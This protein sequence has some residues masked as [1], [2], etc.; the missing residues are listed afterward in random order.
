MASG[1]PRQ[2]HGNP[3]EQTAGQ[4]VPYRGD[5]TPMELHGTMGGVTDLQHGERDNCP[6]PLWLRHVETVAVEAAWRTTLQAVAERS[7]S[8]GEQQNAALRGMGE[9]LGQQVEAAANQAAAQQLQQAHELQAL[10][11][12][13]GGRMEEQEG[14]NSALGVELQNVREQAEM[15]ATEHGSFQAV[16]RGDW[17]RGGE[18]IGTEMDEG[19]EQMGERNAE[20]DAQFLEANQRLA[21]GAE[22]ASE[23]ERQRFAR[24]QE[25]VPG[26]R[27]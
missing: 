21:N 25:D 26:V 27:K 2:D 3:G 13:V 22:L 1:D 12:G 14:A 6:E 20:S 5:A 11:Q 7:N 18:W 15:Q 16:L 17:H 4:T 8:T 9:A 10:Q 23:M 24:T 19:M